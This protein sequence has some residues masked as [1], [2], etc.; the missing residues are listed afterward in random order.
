MPAGFTK[1]NLQLNLHKLEKFNSDKLSTFLLNPR[2]PEVQAELFSCDPGG[3][4][5]RRTEL[6][7]VH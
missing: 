6:K 7:Y 1:E 2:D 5:Y 3:K 4:S